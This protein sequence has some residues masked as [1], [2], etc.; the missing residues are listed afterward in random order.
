MKVTNPSAFP[1]PEA[2]FQ[3]GMS[4]RDYFAAKAMQAWINAKPED[5]F[6]NIAFLSYLAADHMLAERS[7][8]AEV[9][10][11]AKDEDAL[12]AYLPN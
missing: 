10:R 2:N 9:K 8:K 1:V 3:E 11:S 4:L 5:D 7:K 12:L 6:K